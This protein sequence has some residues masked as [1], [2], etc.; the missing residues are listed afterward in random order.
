MSE[1]SSGAPH[2][3]VGVGMHLANLAAGALAL[4]GWVGV[5]PP[6]A[7]GFGIVLYVIQ[8]WESHTV[9]ALTG[10][11]DRRDAPR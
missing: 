11:L 4:A 6:I 3:V 2:A 10:R 5:L 7:A 9:R 1:L 8:I